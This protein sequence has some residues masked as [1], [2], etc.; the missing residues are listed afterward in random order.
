MHRTGTV[1]ILDRT[2]RTSLACLL[3]DRLNFSD[4]A[5]RSI[6]RFFRAGSRQQIVDQ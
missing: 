1:R 2:H 6:L 4:L 3:I 5:G